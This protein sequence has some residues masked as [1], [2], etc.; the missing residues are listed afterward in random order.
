[1]SE[2]KFPEV[3]A[4]ALIINQNK[5]FLFCRSPKWRNKYTVFGGHIEY[6]ESIR[7][8]V[9]REVKEETGLDVKAV[10]VIGVSDSIFQPDFYEKKHFVFIDFLCEYNG[11]DDEIKINEEFKNDYKWVTVDEAEKIDLAKGAKLMLKEYTE[12]LEK[13]NKS[14]K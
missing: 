7:D 8:A 2:K 3:I 14:L 4:G 10:S 6:G 13:R 5:K 11:N 12:Y 1:M 9:T